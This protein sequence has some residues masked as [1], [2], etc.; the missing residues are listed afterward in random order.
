MKP[1][2]PMYLWAYYIGGVLLIIGAI[3]PLFD[4]LS[5]LSAILFSI[6]ILAFMTAQ[7]KQSYEG[8]NITLRRLRRQQLLGAVFW[9]VTAL[10]MLLQ[11]FRLFSVYGEIWKMSFIIGC[12]LQIYTSFRIPTEWEKQQKSENKK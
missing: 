5:L 1:L 6:G 11:L 3:L 7:A 10:L 12:V 8:E 4:E 2:S 9:L